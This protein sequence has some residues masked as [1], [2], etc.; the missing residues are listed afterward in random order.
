MDTIVVA[1]IVAAAV[2]FIGRRV[3]RAVQSSRA[4]KAGCATCGCDDA[5][6]PLAL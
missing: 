3:W 1:L 5:K 6:D 4:A 2:L